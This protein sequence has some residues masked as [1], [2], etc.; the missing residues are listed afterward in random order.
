VDSSVVIG[1]A[2]YVLGALCVVVSVRWNA[3]DKRKLEEATKAAE[4]A[5]EEP[6]PP[7]PDPWERRPG[8]DRLF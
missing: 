3:A 5:G 6:P 8:Q 4:E 7:P 2:L 1:A